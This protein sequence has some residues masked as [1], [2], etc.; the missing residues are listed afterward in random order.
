M[1][2]G[3]AIEKGGQSPPPAENTKQFHLPTRGD[4]SVAK[5]KRK[6][7]LRFRA[8]LGKDEMQLSSGA[9]RSLRTKN[10]EPPM[11]ADERRF[12]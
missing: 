8:A 9:V 6:N 4:R 1:L 7:P 3:K 12:V 2:R 5:R 10:K 11:D